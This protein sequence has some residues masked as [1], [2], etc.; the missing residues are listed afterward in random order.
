MTKIKVKGVG[1]IFNTVLVERD[2][3]CEIA[4]EAAHNRTPNNHRGFPEIERFKES[5]KF[6]ECE[7]DLDGNQGIVVN[8]R[9]VYKGEIEIE[10]DSDS[11]MRIEI[12]D[13]IQGHHGT[14]TDIIRSGVFKNRIKVVQG[15]GH[16]HR[17]RWH[18]HFIVVY[19]LYDEVITLGTLYSYYHK[20]NEEALNDE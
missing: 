12:Y 6:N 10:V 19:P 9:P 4:G 16:D 2:Y 5:L 17:A 1:N 8:Y 14:T 7:F 13:S 18:N 3:A 15:Y 20:K 11:D